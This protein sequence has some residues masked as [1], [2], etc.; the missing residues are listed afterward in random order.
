MTSSL[1]VSGSI[2][3]FM[4]VTERCN[5]DLLEVLVPHL[6]KDVHADLIPV[7]HFL[8]F[9][10]PKKVIFTTKVNGIFVTRRGGESE[11]MRHLSQKKILIEGFLKVKGSA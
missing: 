3:E 2:D 6:C 8:Q 1:K 7:Q 10:P 11:P 9:L 5:P 4:P